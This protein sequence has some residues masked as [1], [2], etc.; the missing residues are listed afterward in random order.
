MYLTVV[1]HCILSEIYLVE[2][3]YLYWAGLEERGL[4][5]S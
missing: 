3:R 5:C 4:D 1:F 2:N